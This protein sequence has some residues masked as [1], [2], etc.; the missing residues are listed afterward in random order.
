[1]HR[2][3]YRARLWKFSQNDDYFKLPCTSA[4]FNKLIADGMPVLRS[5]SKSC[6]IPRD[7]LAGS[8]LSLV[9]HSK[10]HVG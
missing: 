4:L 1:V 9:R 5:E 7:G 2:G 6:A 10:N 8:A 3:V